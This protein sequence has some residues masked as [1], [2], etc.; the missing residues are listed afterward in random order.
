M[1][2]RLIF[3][4][5]GGQGLM[6]AGKLLVAAAMGE[7]KHVTYFP[8]YGSEV[9]G[10]T[11]NCQMVVS[12]SAVLSPVVEEATALLMMNEESMK[13]F[14]PILAEGWLIVLNT[15]MAEPP[16]ET[17]GIRVLGVPATEIAA[18]LGAVQG[19]NVVML[20]ALNEAKRLVAF[21]ALR[22]E[23]RKALRGR[24]AALIPA[25]EQALDAGRDA[26]RA[27]LAK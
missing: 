15:S 23:I 2:E 13:R 27:W 5:S 20:A 14:L 21:D 3:S 19:A 10:G 6:T 24:R 25:N 26:A 1:I 9:R 12:D 16:R 4:G 18:K 17:P 7:G 22:D 8:S 11:A